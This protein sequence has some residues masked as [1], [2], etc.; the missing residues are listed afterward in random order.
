MEIDGA[1]DAQLLFTPAINQDIHAI[2]LRQL[3]ESDPNSLHV[4]IMDQAGFHLRAG[5]G[6]Q[7]ANVRL[8]SLPPYCPELNPVEG[9][10]VSVV[11][12][13][14]DR[15]LLLRFHR[16]HRLQ[17]DDT[18]EVRLPYERFSHCGL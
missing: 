6:R 8:L 14:F 18:Y 9:F 1:N 5:D 7:P 16:C 3:A 13:A 11:P 2:F 10:G 17:I 12:S 15:T 4:V